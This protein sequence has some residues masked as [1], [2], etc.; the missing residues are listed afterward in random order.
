M[1]YTLFIFIVIPCAYTSSST[2]TLEEEAILISAPVGDRV[3]LSCGTLENDYRIYEWLEN[4]KPLEIAENNLTMHSN[5]SLDFRLRMDYADKIL[6]CQSYNS[7]P[8]GSLDSFLNYVYIFAPIVKAFLAKTVHNTTVD[9]EL[10]DVMILNGEVVTEMEHNITE[11]SVVECK[12]QNNLS[13]VHDV[14][15]INVRLDSKTLAIKHGV[16]DRHSYCQSYS[17]VMPKSFVCYSFIENIA[18]EYKEP[19]L[20]SRSRIYSSEPSNHAIENLFDGWDRLLL[21]SILKYSSQP[22]VNF[23]DSNSSDFSSTRSNIVMDIVDASSA[24]WRCVNWAKHL[25]CATSYPRCA[26]LGPE[27]LHGIGYIE[28]PVCMEHCLAVTS[29]FAF[30]TEHVK[31]FSF[32]WNVS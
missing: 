5:G 1:I 31:Q 17:S 26:P 10:D 18:N 28:Y 6:I 11:D 25:T 7:Y 3:I 32:E 30:L 21:S 27:S 13:T 9:W 20:I 19:Y 24:S 23:S 14:A 15:Y 4:G 2:E 12:V 8:N 22:V 16:S 29:L